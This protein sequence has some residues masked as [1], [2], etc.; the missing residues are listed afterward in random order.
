MSPA[1][2]R[3]TYPRYGLSQRESGLLRRF[4]PTE[5]EAMRAYDK[6]APAF[7]HFLHVGAPNV[8]S[9]ARFYELVEGALD[10]NW[11][12]NDGPLV[13]RLEAALADYLGVRE[14]VAL[15]SGTVA[16]EIA[17]RILGLSGEVIVPSLTFVASA[18]ALEWLGIRPVFCDVDSETYCIDPAA[19]EDLI[20]PA[21]SG[22]LGVH[23]FGRP[24]D[25]GSLAQIAA[26]RGLTLFFDA[27][28]AFGCSSH[29]R[30]IG[31]FGACE[32]FS[33]TRPSGSIPSKAALSR[34]T[35]PIWRT[36]RAWRAT[37]GSKTGR[38]GPWGSTAR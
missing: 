23:L 29:G 19:V 5:G 27:A 37:S 30:M 4:T 2:R 38:C 3:Y 33:S 20:S 25:V 9:R 10:A 6:E 7:S 1:D 17:A 36:A 22:I 26:R 8:G 31:N 16:L 28:H 12:T 13:R 18:S 35:I 34:P 21:T 11:L 32:V 24:C 14:C 15:C